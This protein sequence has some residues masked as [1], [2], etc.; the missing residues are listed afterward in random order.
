MNN[1]IFT[2]AI[3]GKPNVGKSA[4]FNRI[5]KEKISIVDDEKGVTRDRIY[6]QAEWLTKKFLIVDTGGLTNEDLD[7][8]EQIQYQTDIAIKEA[9]IIFFILSFKEGILDDD[10]WISK[11][12][13]KKN[14]KV[15]LVLNKY[16]NKEDEFFIYDYMK[17]GFGL[18]L[19]VSASHGIGIG[20]L[21]DKLIDQIKN[22]K[23]YTTNNSIRFSIIGKA[24][25]GK[26]SLVN[27]I[28]K[29]ERVLVSNIP[30]TTR[31][32]VDSYLKFN[33]KNFTV[34][35]TA[36]IK[37]KG[38]IGERVEKYSYLRTIKSIVNSDIVLLVIDGSKTITNLDTIIGG[39]IYQ[40]KKPAIIVF[41]KTDLLDNNIEP[42]FKLIQKV[43]D[44]F[45][46]LK[47]AFIVFTSALNNKNI[48]NLLKT[49][50]DVYNLMHKKVQTSI[51]N[52]VIVKMQ[53]FNK[54]H[55]FNG[56]RLK[57]YYGL[58]AKSIPPT[59]I[60][61]VNNKKYLHFS[62]KRY[63][64]NQ[65]RENFNFEG[66]PINLIFRNKKLGGN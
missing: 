13:Q 33:N 31:D 56:N 50:F 43:K 10:L 18:P 36:G 28:L 30:G 61:F 4:L 16:D 44:R 23:D 7:F 21:L 37:K 3:I 27:S 12:L 49:I 5:V 52:E 51:L 24:N 54:P 35:D 32:S 8:Q 9:D 57:I 59:F 6:G 55:I 42:R 63:I 41:N 26:S 2:V 65:I 1:K 15:I 22:I 66:V 29:E 17:L 14:K 40:E 53:L 64:N 20:N 58:Q 62:Y 38:K 25:V 45:K 34:V 47:Y 48:I 46:Y 39:L 19:L 11:R 60:L